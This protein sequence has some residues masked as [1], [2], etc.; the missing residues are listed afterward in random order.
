M[1][2]VDSIFKAIAH[3]TRREIIALL[4]VS[5]RS[6]KELTAE[7]EMSQSAIS[8]HLRELKDADLVASGRVG[9]EQKYRLTAAPLKVVLDWSTKYRRFFD[10]S[11][12]A[13][14][15]VPSGKSAN[16]VDKKGRRS[17]GR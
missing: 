1:V 7:F 11:G 10:P 16:R 4:S 17:N 13:W 12:H 5:E 14:A 8:Q 9:L 15:F 6:V 3:P 2:S